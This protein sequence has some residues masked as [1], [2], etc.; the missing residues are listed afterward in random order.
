[1]PPIPDVDTDAVAIWLFTSGTTGEP[2]AAVLR[3]GTSP[4]T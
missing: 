1:M 4:R 3:H 2:K